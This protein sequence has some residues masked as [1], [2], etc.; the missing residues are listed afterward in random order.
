MRR[1]LHRLLHAPRLPHDLRQVPSMRQKLHRL[2]QVRASEA[3][4]ADDEQYSN[5]SSEIENSFISYFR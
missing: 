3:R 5:I 2:E 4:S 1:D